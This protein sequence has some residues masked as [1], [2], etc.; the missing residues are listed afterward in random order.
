[1]TPISGWTCTAIACLRTGYNDDEQVCIALVCICCVGFIIAWNAWRGRTSDSDMR[2]IA[3]NMLTLFRPEDAL[4][5]LFVK[6]LGRGLANVFQSSQTMTDSCASIATSIRKKG[7]IAVAA[8]GPTTATMRGS[9]V[10]PCTAMM[11]WSSVGATTTMM[12]ESSP[13]V[14]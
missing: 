13:H 4:T 10:G 7:C 8:V 6:V 1:V 3:D 14:R 5:M 12:S 9:L 11:S 2:L